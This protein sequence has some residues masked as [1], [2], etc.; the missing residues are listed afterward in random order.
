[1]IVKCIANNGSNGEPEV[2]L[3]E[4]PCRECS[5]LDWEA[6]DDDDRPSLQS[7]RIEGFPE[8]YAR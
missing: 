2:P 6:L 7:F 3:W 4:C 5:R 8:V 1:M